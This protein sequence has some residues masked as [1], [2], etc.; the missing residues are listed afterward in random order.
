[1]CARLAGVWAGGSE[2]LLIRNF[3]ARYEA[4]GQLHAAAA[5]PARK[6]PPIP[7]E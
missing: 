4:N 3:G 5:V 1:M 6:E 7:I 2:A